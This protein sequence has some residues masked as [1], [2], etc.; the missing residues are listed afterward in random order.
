MS[1]YPTPKQTQVLRLIAGGPCSLRDIGKALDTTKANAQQLVYKVRRLGMVT[2]TEAG[3]V[4]T[5][6]GRRWIEM[7][8][9]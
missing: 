9:R 6:S 2:R 8:P 5:K 3:L 1:T 7:V 4:L